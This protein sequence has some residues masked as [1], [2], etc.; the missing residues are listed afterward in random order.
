MTLEQVQAV[1]K[2]INPEDS[3]MVVLDNEHHLFDQ[4]YEQPSL[5]WDDDLEMITSIEPNT[6]YDVYTK[7]VCPML[8]RKTTYDMIQQIFIFKPLPSASEYVKETKN[9]M[10]EDNG[11]KLDQLLS[12][13]A[14]LGRSIRKTVI[15]KN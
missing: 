15:N 12:K 14:T 2:E 8:V 11:K 5:I 4:D 9:I 3:V 6:S 1:R 7:R 13:I 10:D